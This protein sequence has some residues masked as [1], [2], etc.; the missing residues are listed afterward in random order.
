MARKPA[1]FAHRTMARRTVVI[2]LLAAVSAVA[3]PPCAWAYIDPNAS[4]LLFQ[5]VSP[6][7]AL[8]IGFTVFV[9]D[10]IKERLRRLV[11]LI[12]KSSDLDDAS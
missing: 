8:A 3:E 9:R 4:S 1:L 6:I 10:A 2:V 12:R 5:I 11:N 7:V